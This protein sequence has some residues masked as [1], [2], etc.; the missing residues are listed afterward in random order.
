MSFDK[1][2]ISLPKIEVKKSK[3]SKKINLPVKNW[4][5]YG[6]KILTIENI[7][8]IRIKI[9]KKKSTKIPIEIH[10]TSIKP[11]DE[12][13]IFDLKNNNPQ[14]HL[15]YTNI[16]NFGKDKNCF[17]NIAPT[18][19][20][21]LSMWLKEKSIGIGNEFFFTRIGSGVNSRL[22]FLTQTEKDEYMKKNM[23]ELNLK[24]DNKK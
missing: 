4:L 11:I 13:K 15:N 12:Q 2:T 20:D 17:W 5:M 16:E 21:I 24:K 9:N 22:I 7:K 10:L 19:Y 1:N 3:K 18:H 6:I 23:R 14:E 8:P